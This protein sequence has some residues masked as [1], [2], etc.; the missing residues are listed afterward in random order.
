MTAIKVGAKDSVPAGARIS[1]DTAVECLD[2]RR[3][4]C[5]ERYRR[6]GVYVTPHRMT[7]ERIATEV[8]RLVQNAACKENGWQQT[9]ADK[10]D[11][12]ADERLVTLAAN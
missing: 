4:P 11:L 9:E 8:A 7:G 6:S 3:T 1:Y 2:S 10:P 5:G 12:R